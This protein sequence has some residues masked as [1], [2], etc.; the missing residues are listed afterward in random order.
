MAATSTH[1]PVPATKTDHTCLLFKLPPELRNAIY[2]YT[3]LSSEP[4]KLH[5]KTVATLK[6]L[7]DTC[8]EIRKEAA[9]IFWAEN[10]FTAKMEGSEQARDVL[11]AA[12]RVHCQSIQRLVVTVTFCLKSWHQTP[13]STVGSLMDSRSAQLHEDGKRLTAML[14]DQGVRLKVVKVE[15][16]ELSTDQCDA[17]EC[18]MISALCETNLSTVVTMF[19]ISLLIRGMEEKVRSR[20]IGGG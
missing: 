8:T 1:H 3:L 16:A 18:P 19:G 20:N 15:R 11:A 10:D 4:I 6:A 9:S 14:H 12:G 5:V 13:R 17:L 2:R 7:T